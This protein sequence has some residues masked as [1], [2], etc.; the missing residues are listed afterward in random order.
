MQLEA[1]DTIIIDGRVVMR[2]RRLQTADEDEI[3]SAATRAAQKLAKRIEISGS[4][5]FL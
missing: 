5:R 3:G 2:I 4:S 1:A